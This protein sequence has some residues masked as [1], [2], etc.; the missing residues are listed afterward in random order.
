[1]ESMSRA[2]WTDGRLDDLNHRV[3]DL[4]HRVDDLSRRMDQGFNRVDHDLRQMSG[5]IDA[6]Q[7]TMV[8]A[9]VA[10]TAAM[11]A[12]FTGLAALIGTQL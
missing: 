10:M 2:T 9:V 3:D 11:L 6:M 8:H 12:G 7:S 1:M 4:S 5:R